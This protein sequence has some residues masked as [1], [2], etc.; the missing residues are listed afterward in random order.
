MAEVAAAIRAH[1]LGAHHPVPGIGL[2]VDRLLG[3]RCVEG[4]PAAARVVLRLGAEELGAAARAAIRAWL[5]GLVVFTRKRRLGTLFAQDAVPLRIQLRAP[6]LLGLLDF[7][8]HFLPLSSS[9]LQ[10]CDW[11]RHY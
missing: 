8:H 7:R 1:H 10:S 11:R 9:S 6:L 5:E 2:L 3:G 4:R